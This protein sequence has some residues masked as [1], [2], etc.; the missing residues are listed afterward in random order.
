MVIASI[1]PTYR[2]TDTL[3]LGVNYSYL[4]RDNNYYDQIQDQF[5]PAKQKHS[6]GGSATVALTPT[7]NLTFRGS[8]AWIKQEDSAFLVTTFTP[9]PPAFGFQPPALKFESW[10]ASVA[11]NFSF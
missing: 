8:H 4:Y 3:R 9:P 6:V 1:E 2:V 11:A 5:I 7:A 10:A